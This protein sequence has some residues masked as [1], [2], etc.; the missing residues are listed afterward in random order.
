[1]AVKTTEGYYINFKEIKRR[2]RY[3]KERFEIVENK[4]VKVLDESNNPITD[5]TLHFEVILNIYEN[6]TKQNK[7]EIEVHFDIPYQE[8]I[9]DSDIYI[10]LKTMIIKIKN[11][12]GYTILNLTQSSNC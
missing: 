1:M 11:G 5:D 7:Q 6:D 9:S 4:A 12:F 8:Q 3:N 10:K 2:L